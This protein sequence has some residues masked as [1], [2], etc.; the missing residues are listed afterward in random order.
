MN[1]SKPVVMERPSD[2]SVAV[3]LFLRQEPDEDEQDDR[4]DEGDDDEGVTTATP[5]ERVDKR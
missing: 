1:S 5:S 3:E 4:R 2:G